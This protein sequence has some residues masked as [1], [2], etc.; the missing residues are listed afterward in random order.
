MTDTAN[1]TSQALTVHIKGSKMKAALRVGPT[2]IHT[3][4][5]AA[6]NQVDSEVWFTLGGPDAG[7]LD[8][9]TAEA[10]GMGF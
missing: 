2:E 10:L 9:K 5:V 1:T 7:H 4:D 3:F 6:V 8:A